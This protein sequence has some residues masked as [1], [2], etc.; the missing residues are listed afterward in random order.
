MIGRAVRS[1]Q[2]RD[3]PGAHSHLAPRS[4][5]G[6]TVY[7]NTKFRISYIEITVS[8]EFGR[9]LRTG[10]RSPLGHRSD[11][12]G[13]AVLLPVP[14]RPAASS[15]PPSPILQRHQV[16]RRGHRDPWPRVA[17]ERARSR[18]L[19]ALTAVLFG[20]GSPLHSVFPQ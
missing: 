10:A 12:G 16:P 3:P 20:F 18:F 13:V 1:G 19:P 7:E 17:C 15:R 14:S 11:A 9:L 8:V 2:L 5:C 4:K 6:G